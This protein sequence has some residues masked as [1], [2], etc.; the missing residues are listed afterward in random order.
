MKWK[1]LALSWHLIY[2]A[3]S[4]PS[5]NLTGREA[6]SHTTM[7][8]L[9]W[10]AFGRSGGSLNLSLMPFGIGRLWQPP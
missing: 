2:H 7:I 10:R 5:P 9:R 3:D 1:L 4:A 8:S 6:W